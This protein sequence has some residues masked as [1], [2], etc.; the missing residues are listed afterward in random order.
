MVLSLLPC[1]CSQSCVQQQFPQGGSTGSRPGAEP[2]G[3]H[4]AHL[5]TTTQALC[6]HPLCWAVQQCSCSHRTSG[7]WKQAARP[8]H[9]CLSI[10]PACWLTMPPSPQTL[11]V[12]FCI[13]FTVL[14]SSAPQLHMFLCLC[15][16][17]QSPMQRERCRKSFHPGARP[18]HLPDVL[19]SL[20]W[21]NK[22]CAPW[23]RWRVPTHSPAAAPTLKAAES[24]LTSS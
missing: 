7:G 4:P 20:P 9:F 19:T 11:S 1:R 12:T 8:S 18:L 15:P 3:G 13:S 14:S 23:H 17:L 21:E 16:A 6:W 22:A 5:S 10:T 24:K 2:Q